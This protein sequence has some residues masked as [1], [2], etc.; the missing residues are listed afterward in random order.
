VTALGADNAFAAF[1]AA[2]LSPAPSTLGGVSSPTEDVAVA[3]AF[4]AFVVGVGALVGV[5]SAALW[6][7]GQRP[8]Y[9]KGALLG[10]GAAGA[11]VLLPGLVRGTF[12][13]R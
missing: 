10:A 12:S 8:A 6:A 9:G 4:V 1:L 2:P 7:H 3:G 13:S 5:G 11:L